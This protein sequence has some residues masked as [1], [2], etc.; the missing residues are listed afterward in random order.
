MW[1]LAKLYVKGVQIVI[2]SLENVSVK[3]GLSICSP[4]R[5]FQGSK[6]RVQSINSRKKLSLMHV[7]IN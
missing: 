5:I 7:T 2:H 1:D 3:V 4:C 6:I